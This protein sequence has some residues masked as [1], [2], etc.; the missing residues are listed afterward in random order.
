VSNLE[1]LPTRLAGLIAP[2]ERLEGD[3]YDM[4]DRA[5]TFRLKELARSRGPGARFTLLLD[6]AQLL[7]RSESVRHQLRNLFQS[8][9]R[10]GLRVLVAGPPHAMRELAHDPSGSPF[11]NIFLPYRLGPMSRAELTRLVRTP[12]GEEY[13]VTDEAV[14]RLTALSGGRR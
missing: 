13:T 10:D 8:R 5:L 14:E 9:R 2:G 4:L 12:L 3:A 1:A 6:E 7:T 11:L